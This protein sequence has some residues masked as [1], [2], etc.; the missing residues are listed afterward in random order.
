MIEFEHTDTIKEWLGAG[1]INFIGKPHAGKDTHADRFVERFDG[2]KFGGG[3]ILRTM[4]LNP[5]VKKM[6]DNGELI[7]SEVF[8]ETILPLIETEAK[9][10]RP[11]L[12]SAVGRL[13]GEQERVM[14]ILAM[15]GHPLRAVVYLDADDE[16]VWER[17]RIH[18]AAKLAGL[19]SAV[20]GPRADDDET[21][22]ETRLHEFQIKTIPV[23]EDY[24]EREMLIEVDATQPIDDVELTIL[25]NLAIRSHFE[26]S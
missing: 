25:A 10:G 13:D 7:P 15:T 14:E 4:Q 18:E 16:T 17:F 26:V 1:A 12:L 5:K 6:M 8:L 2:I 21:K 24:S 20:R 23:I 19:P 11:L 3:D 22:L 9:E